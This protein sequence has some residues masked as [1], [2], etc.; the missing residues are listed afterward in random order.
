MKALLDT[1]SL[2]WA[3]HNYRLSVIT[4]GNK[5]PEAREG[6]LCKINVSYKMSTIIPGVWISVQ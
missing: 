4:Y 1:W 2:K 5:S 3:L 6:A